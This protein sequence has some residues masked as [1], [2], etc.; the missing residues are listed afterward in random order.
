[1]WTPVLALQCEA[2]WQGLWGIIFLTCPH[3]VM[4]GNLGTTPAHK[5]EKNSAFTA[6]FVDMCGI[7]Y[8]LRAILCYSIAVW[9]SELSKFGLITMSLYNIAPFLLILKHHTLFPAWLV[10]PSLIVPVM[11]GGLCGLAYYM[12]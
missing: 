11:E 9:A 10:L 2:A 8:S 7:S 3:L 6:Y 1:M 4:L 12:L 5:T